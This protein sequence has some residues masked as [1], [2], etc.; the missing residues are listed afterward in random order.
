MSSHHVVRDTQEP[1]LIIANGEAC[2]FDLVQ[3][4]LEWSPIVM[5][6]DGALP[7]VLELGIK[8]DIVLGDFDREHNPE[9]ALAHQ[10]PV[11]IIHTPDQNKTDL[12]K[13]IDLLLS[14]NHKAINIVWATGRRAD[15]TINNISNLARYKNEATLVIYDD[16]SKIYC[17]PNSFDK[18][19]AKGT[20]IS[21][22]PI[23]KV[24]GVKTSGLKYNLHSESL[25]LG[26]KSGSS[27][28]AEQDGTVC[29]NYLDGF[30]LMME[31][32]D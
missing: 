25:E 31:C 24:E 28:E 2:S 15:H 12:E 13:G 22:I 8:I 30:L 20:P 7:R 17:L 27:N 19:Y 26:F 6:L 14:R 10:H 3:Q 29:I 1:A 11:E 21:L 5:V 4:L 32:R 18:W 23:G 16:Y 9:E